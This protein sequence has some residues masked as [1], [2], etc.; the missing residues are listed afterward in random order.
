MKVLLIIGVLT[1]KISTRTVT[2]ALLGVVGSFLLCAVAERQVLAILTSDRD[3]G[4]FAEHLP[5]TLHPVRS[6]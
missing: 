3:F 2:S 5:V 1:Y 6:G 4:R